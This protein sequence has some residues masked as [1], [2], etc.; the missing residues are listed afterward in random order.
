MI[1]IPR[2]A[3]M[4]LLTRNVNQTTIS[5]FP[6]SFVKNTVKDASFPQITQCEWSPPWSCNFLKTNLRKTR[7]GAERRF[8]S[9]R[10]PWTSELTKCTNGDTTKRS[11]WSK[12]RKI[13]MAERANLQSKLSS[14]LDLRSLIVWISIYTYNLYSI[15]LKIY[16]P[17]WIW[18]QIH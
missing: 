13:K 9:A 2:R 11:E 15:F 3:R 6:T 8:N 4:I 1:A 17:R 10:K 5:R 7:R 12:A 16:C 14:L 18:F